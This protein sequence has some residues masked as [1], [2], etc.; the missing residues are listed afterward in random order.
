MADSA[1]F[2]VSFDDQVTKNA[3]T[4]ADSLTELKVRQRELMDSQR[5]LG[6]SMSAL[7]R[8]GMKNAPEYKQLADQF[9]LNRKEMGSLHVAAIQAGTSLAKVKPPPPPEV[10]ELSKLADEMLEAGASMESLKAR[11]ME[12]IAANQQLAASMNALA[13]AGVKQGPDFDRL[14]ASFKK[15]QKEIGALHLAADK[16]GKSLA[17]FQVPTAQTKR[18]MGSLADEIARQPGVFG[19]LS[20]VVGKIPPGFA[21][22][23]AAAAAV[24]AVLGVVA[25]VAIS[26][27]TKLLK[28]ALA[29]AD[30][31]RSQAL[32]WQAAGRGSIQTAAAIGGAVDSIA[33]KVAL[34][35]EEIGSIGT[36]MAKM[37]LQG[38]DLSS[39]MEAIAI[40][41]AVGLDTGPIKAQIQQA[42]ALGQSVDAVTKRIRDQYG[43]I[44]KAQTLGLSHQMRKLGDDIGALFSDVDI[45]PFLKELKSLLSI[46]DSTS[47]S[48][49]AMRTV[50][51]DV[52]TG[53]FGAGEVG[54]R[55]LKRVVQGMI[56]TLFDMAIEAKRATKGLR[57][58]A[59][60]VDFQK[61]A[62]SLKPLGTAAAIAAVGLGLIVAGIVAVVAWIGVATA[63]LL[64]GTGAIVAGVVAVSVKMVSIGKDFA[65]GLVSGITG[66][67]SAVVDAAKRLATGALNA[68]KSVLQIKS[69]SRVLM[70]V[71]LNTAEGFA[72]G[73][74]DGEQGVS[75][76][77]S[78][79]AEI[80][81]DTLGD[82]SAVGGRQSGPQSAGNTY[83]VSIYGVKDADQLTDA[84]M[85]E[86]FAETLQIVLG[87]AGL[88]VN[89][90]PA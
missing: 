42:R 90:G 1:S 87:V 13:A 38:N 47:E 40:A 77:A 64:A 34:S 46:F 73:M 4:A 41:Q 53:I 51:S 75:T 23:A 22:V 65:T 3:L 8:A 61:M 7:A 56:L 88:P 57:E 80:P 20:T 6:S 86:R 45:E 79:L 68:V 30:A 24:V 36:E 28:F 10:G 26:A 21:A 12:L 32:L 5:D 83:H 37:R 33:S 49:K 18:S 82:A 60:N 71:G 44:A 29:S 66:G 58:M 2:R 72:L 54:V 14:A 50:I 48:G 55:G 85:A 39:A 63:V 16:T 74:E 43:G 70:D 67:I 89:P 62:D 19:K 9:A 25:A 69:P 11:E 78:G 84:G 52:F 76:A 27:T 31:Y 17:G 35:R 15:N 59:G 81:A